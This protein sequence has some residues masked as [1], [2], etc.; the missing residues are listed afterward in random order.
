VPP[1]RLFSVNVGL[2]KAVDTAG[3]VVETAIWKYLTTERSTSPAPCSASPGGSGP[4]GAGDAIEVDLAGRP[5]HGVSVRLVSD[6]MLVDHCSIPRAK[7]APQ[8]IGT[9]REQ[10]GELAA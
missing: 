10:M 9:L 2:P 1:A 6:A 4:L 3:R 5:D 7:E 8:L